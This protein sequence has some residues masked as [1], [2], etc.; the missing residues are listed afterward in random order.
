MS[1]VI[2]QG[3]RTMYEILEVATI[4]PGGSGTLTN[5]NPYSASVKI[6]SRNVVERMDKRVG[7]QEV[8]TALEFK[9]LCN[10]EDQVALVCEAIRKLRSNKSPFYI[11][12]DLPQTHQQ[13]QKM[14]VATVVSFVSGAEF[15]KKHGSPVESKQTPKS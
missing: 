2:S 13:G 9:I 12:G 15:L 1:Q 5:G 11:S 4:K 8:E 6:R 7:V 10:S 14:D 3:F